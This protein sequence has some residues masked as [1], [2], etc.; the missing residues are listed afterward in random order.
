MLPSSKLNSAS[1]P[2]GLPFTKDQSASASS[3]L[4]DALQMGVHL[5]ATV[6]AGLRMFDLDKKHV[7]GFR[8]SL[9]WSCFSHVALIVLIFLFLLVAQLLG[10]MFPLF[11]PLQLKQRDLEFVLVEAPNVK[12]RDPNTRLRAEKNTRSGGQAVKNLPKAQP[13]KSAGLPNQARAS[14]STS[15]QQPKLQPRK[16]PVKAPQK[17]IEKPAPK[18]PE[19][20]KPSQKPAPT[21]PAPKAPTA[22]VPKATSSQTKPVAMPTPPGAINLPSTPAPTQVS[23][24]PVLPTSGSLSGGRGSASNGQPG[25]SGGGRPGPMQIPGNVSPSG[26]M[27]GGGG[28]GGRNS[29]NQFGSPG[30]GGGN[31]G[32]DAIAEPDFGPYIAE[33][34]RRIKRNWTPPSDNRN[35]RIVALF[36]I[37]RDGGLRKLVIQRSS[38][39]ASADDAAIAAIR[40]SSPFRPLPPNYRGN[41]ID[42]QFIFDYNVFAGRGGGVSLQ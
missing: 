1:V 14:Q 39:V 21:P 24:G 12:P 5:P 6:L 11:D 13:L 17:T 9:F 37:G 42:V 10:W 26:G 36:T 8:A 22:S 25:A 31:A 15:R 33:L 34:Q 28:N 38:G 3:S 30:G 41:E 27:P 4:A 20:P 7:L 40:A 23:A 16:Q 35:K 18:V 19:S 29:T 32:V 2:T